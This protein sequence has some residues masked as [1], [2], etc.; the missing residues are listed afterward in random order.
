MLTSYSSLIKILLF[1]NQLLIF[2]MRSAV[3]FFSYIQDVRSCLFIKLPLRLSIACL[4]TH[5]FMSHISIMYIA[6][7]LIC[8]EINYIFD[9]QLYNFL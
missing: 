2:W 6:A 3:K 7:F 4:S 5:S 9:I 1:D 8:K